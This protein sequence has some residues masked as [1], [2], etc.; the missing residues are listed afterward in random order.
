VAALRAA[1]ADKQLPDLEN[2]R[3]GVSDAECRLPPIL[4][5]A[6]QVAKWS[7]GTAAPMHQE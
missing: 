5:F 2:E 1:F 7:N 6:L 4:V 3:Y